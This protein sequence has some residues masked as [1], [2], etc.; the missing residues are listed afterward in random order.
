[1]Y[2]HVY[3]HTFRAVCTVYAI[4][5]TWHWISP[6]SVLYYFSALFFQTR[7]IWKTKQSTKQIAQNT[8]KLHLSYNATDF[9]GRYTGVHIH[10]NTCAHYT[11]I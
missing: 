6:N 5:T 4:F 11:T 7:N 10:C 8:F 9:N 3:A 1:M 2:I